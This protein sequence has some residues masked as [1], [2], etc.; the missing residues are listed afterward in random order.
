MK[1]ETQKNKAARLAGVTNQV[2]DLQRLPTVDALGLG[3][4]RILTDSCDVCTVTSCGRTA[5]VDN[6]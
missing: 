4:H 5:V 1:M 2:F 6:K 3:P